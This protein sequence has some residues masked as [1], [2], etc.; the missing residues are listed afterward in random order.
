MKYLSRMA[1]AL[2]VSAMVTAG[3]ATGG[4]GGG[5]ITLID[6]ESGMENF[7][8]IGDAN[9]RA[10][11]GAIVADN[12]KGGHLVSKGSYRDFELRVEF[13]AATDTNS[14]VFIRASD[15]NKVGSANS[16]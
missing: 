14:G 9:W 15:R 16:Y 2:L 6:G 10:E 11:D 1:C 12:G 8:R 13:W 3:C 4:G 5:W 7:D